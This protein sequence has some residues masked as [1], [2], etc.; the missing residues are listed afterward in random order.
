[1]FHTIKD[2]E[3]VGYLCF[4]SYDFNETQVSNPN[5]LFSSKKSSSQLYV[6][7]IQRKG[8]RSLLFLQNIQFFSKNIKKSESR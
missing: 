5:L 2:L 6:A 8:D 1:M 7:K 4:G 3:G